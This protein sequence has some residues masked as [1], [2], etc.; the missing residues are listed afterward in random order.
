VAQQRHGQYGD[1]GSPDTAGKY[2]LDLLR[3]INAYALNNRKQ[4]VNQTLYRGTTPVS[5]LDYAVVP[6]SLYNAGATAEVA[7]PSW[8]ITRSGHRMLLA[9]LPLRTIHHTTPKPKPYMKWKLD[10][11]VDNEHGNIL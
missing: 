7:G 1:L 11:F 10:R 8:H 6:A 3:D 2:M 9:T 5:T 4:G